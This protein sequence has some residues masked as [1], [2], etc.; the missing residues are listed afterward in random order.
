MRYPIGA[1]PSPR[2]R[3]QHLPRLSRWLPRAL[4]VPASAWIA[5]A[6]AL[7]PVQE[8]D[9]NRYAGHWYEIA[10]I[11]GFLQS[12]CARDTEV[13]YSQRRKRRA[14]RADALHP[15]GRNARIDRV[16]G[17][18]SRPRRSGSAQGDHRQFPR[19]V[20]VSL[21][22]GIDRR[23]RRSG[24]PLGG[25]GRI[26]RCVTGASSRA[27]RCCPTIR[28]GARPPRS[29]ASSSTCANSSPRRRP[30]GECSRCASAI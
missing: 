30:A 13:E 7:I 10:S 11:P 15:D 28:C 27:S 9:L 3:M 19:R 8:F 4:L 17:A 21:R 25:A 29:A 12:R 20:V 22:T 26:H 24:L 23:R 5:V 18:Q 16:A 1:R 14:G 2:M 6:Y